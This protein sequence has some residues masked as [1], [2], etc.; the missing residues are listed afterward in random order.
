MDRELQGIERV[1][2][3]FKDAIMQKYLK[4]NLVYTMPDQEMKTTQEIF[5]IMTMGQ[6]LTLYTMPD[7]RFKTLHFLSH[8]NETIYLNIVGLYGVMEKN[9]YINT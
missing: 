1:K 4:L 2:E 3:Y 5:N 8:D 7:D 6:L 9:G